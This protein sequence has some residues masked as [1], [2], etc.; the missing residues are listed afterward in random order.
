[1]SMRWAGE[2]ALRQAR[3][4]LVRTAVLDIRAYDRYTHT[5][6]TTEPKESP[7]KRAPGVAWVI[8]ALFSPAITSAATHT[9]NAGA[10]LQTVLNAALPGDVI[11]LQAGATFTGNFVLPV[12]SGATYITIRS[13]ALDSQL[14]A[15][16]VRITPAAASLL[17]KIVAAG[18]AP[19]LR[20]PAGSHHWKLQFVEVVANTGG[21]GDIIQLGSGSQTVAAN[22]P[23]H[24]ILDRVYI[25]GRP[26]TG[27]KRGVALNSGE[28]TIRD[29]WISDIKSVGQDTQAICGW[30]GPGPYLIQNNYLEGA[31]ENVM[32]GGA[33]PAIPNLV[34]S[35]I[36]ILRNTFRKPVTWRA[37][38]LAT[39][40]PTAAGSTAGG[41]L[42][43][44]TYAY[45]V[46]AYRECGNG[47]WCRS[48]TSTTVAAAVASGATGSVRVTWPAVSGATT[49][50]VYGRTSAGLNQYWTVATTSFTDTG[51]LGTAGSSSGSATKWTVKNLLELKNARR[52]LIEGNRFEY[53]W[54]QDQ[55]GYALNFKPAQSGKA[56]WTTV[57]DITVQFNTFAH[58]A[59]GIVLT[60]YDATY[61]SQRMA[62]ILIRHNL[63]TDVSAARWGGSGGFL[64]VGSGAVDVTV[65]HNTIDHDGFVVNGNGTAMTR[66]TYTNNLSRHN[67]WGIY[68]D[69][70]GSGLVSISV[71][72]PGSVIRRNVLAG[73]V[74]SKYPVDNYFP[75]AAEF[76]GQFVDAAA[77][78]YRLGIWS[79]YRRAGTDGT[80]I[81]ANIDAIAA[82]QR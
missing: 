81:G 47:K 21:Y 58:V 7:V 55:K 10:N 2:L 5:S 32:F 57:E 78:N 6:R 37:A 80:D 43:A 19:A 74:A 38:I 79:P 71:Y 40:K 61:G 22:Q 33:D 73:G 64:V 60:G 39:P 30:N 49:Y 25:H 53:S 35:D 24:F 13:A 69:G 72:F 27:A 1:M 8:C 14:P 4:Q 42:P 46:V 51:A 23:H 36:R 44:G 56:P 11:L 15:A 18:T 50:R 34:P 75:P 65:D 59:G 20:A 45:A 54:A 31:A 41:T 52:V 12:K 77:G 68:G 70:K 48:A 29:S 62:R 76:I 3:A 66:F 16:G 82:A 9:V 63:L 67:T 28:A 17:P 26:N